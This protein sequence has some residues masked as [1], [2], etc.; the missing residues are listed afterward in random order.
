M[1]KTIFYGGDILTMRDGS[2]YEEAVLTE[3]GVIRALGSRESLC[4][5]HPDARLCNLRGATLMPSFIDSHSH[6]TALASTMGLTNLDG[7][8]G[9]EDIVG[10][11]VDFKEARGL[12]DTDWII[13]FGYDHNML[14][15]K[16][17]PTRQTL[18]IEGLSNPVMISHRSGHMGVLNTA[19]LQALGITAQTPD[20]K[21]G[22]IGRESDGR[23]PNGYL[24]ETAFINLSNKIPQPGLSQQLNQLD[25]AQQVYLSYGITTVQ[26]GLTKKEGWE[27]LKVASKEG[28]LLLDTVCYPDLEQHK[29]IAQ[30]PDYQKKYHNRLKVGGYKIFLDG[31]PQGRTAW[32]SEPYENA[33]DGYRGYPVHADSVVRNFVNTALRENLQLLAHCNGDAAA[34]QLID[35][36]QAAKE[37][38]KDPG[39][40]RPVMIHAQTVRYDQ[41]DR[42]AELGIVASFFVSHVHYWGDVHLQNLGMARAGRISPARSAAEK[43][44]VYTF[45]QDAPVNPPNMM[46]TVWCAVNRTTKS[47]LVLGDGERVTT[48]QALKAVTSNAAYQYFEEGRKGTIEPGKLADFVILDRNPL[49]TDPKE[50]RDIKVMKTIK[51][52]RVLF[53]RN[54]ELL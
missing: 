52:D 31:S 16:A 25:A 36:F 27:M 44:V 41:L 38:G 46:D 47:G 14:I 19:A 51:E 13:C 22:R 34:Q 23:T 29:D 32:L 8:E 15:E 40:I 49:R 5:G 7:V 26:D 9:F 2:L 30:E 1:Q 6:L 37:E 48:L 42:M 10:R 33:P 28:R 4:A 24:E 54:E 12:S 45:H 53:E 50:L 11:I 17:H 39:S 3:G 43:G 21:G 20:P 35:A 18:D